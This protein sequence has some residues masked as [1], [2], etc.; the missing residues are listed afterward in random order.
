VELEE[1][2]PAELELW[3]YN[4]RIVEG[5]EKKERGEMGKP[6]NVQSPTKLFFGTIAS[7]LGLLLAV[8]GLLAL[9]F[10][11]N[12]GVDVFIPNIFLGI[13]LGTVGYSLGQV[14]L[15]IAVIVL[16]TLIM[17]AGLTVNVLYPTQVS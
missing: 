8:A 12:S 11:P 3:L 10:I 5:G 7:G 14:R 13:V 17:F 15:G 2:V 16:T 4:K 9:L 1:D 6:Q